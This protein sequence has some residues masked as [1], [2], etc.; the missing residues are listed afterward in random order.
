MRPV[1]VQVIVTYDDGTTATICDKSREG[2]FNEAEFGA[3]WVRPVEPEWI[4][5]ENRAAGHRQTGPTSFTL[6]VNDFS[7]AGKLL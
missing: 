2:G 5:G 6:T 7:D 3:H 4:A 1:R